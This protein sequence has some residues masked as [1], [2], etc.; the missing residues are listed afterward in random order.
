MLL[1]DPLSIPDYRNEVSKTVNLTE[2]KGGAQPIDEML[3][4]FVRTLTN[5]FSIKRNAMLKTDVAVV[6]TKADIPGLDE[7]IGKSAVLKNASSDKSKVRYEVQN[8]LCEQFLRDYNEHNFLNSLKSRFKTVQFFACSALG[9]VYNGK[10]FVASNVEEPL[11]WLVRKRSKVI[12]K[13][14]K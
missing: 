8:K 2:Y 1:I 14:I 10:P 12:D 6:F 9:H 11:F 7:K 5:I 3:D 13:V 4:T